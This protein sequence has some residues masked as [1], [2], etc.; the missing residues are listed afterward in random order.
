MSM[1]GAFY[2]PSSLKWHWP[3]QAIIQL[4]H[5]AHKWKKG[6]LGK[7]LL[8]LPI[9]PTYVLLALAVTLHHKAHNWSKG[10]I[11]KPRLRFL[12]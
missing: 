4:T 7:T 8:R 5:I 9:Y 2:S 1:G 3:P 11:G 6:V 12:M 10:V